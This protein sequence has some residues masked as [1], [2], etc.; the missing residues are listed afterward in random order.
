MAFSTQDS[1]DLSLDTQLPEQYY[2]VMHNDDYSSF[3]FVID[4]LEKVFRKT[5][6]EAHEIAANIHEKGSEIC[7]VYPFE[8]AETKVHQ[9]HALAKANNFPLQCTIESY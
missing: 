7:G 2:V 6:E 4:V 9:V 1:T 3:D 5:K 8:I